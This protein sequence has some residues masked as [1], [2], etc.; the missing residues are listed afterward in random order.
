VKRGKRSSSINYFSRLDK[1]PKAP[2]RLFAANKNK[3]PKNTLSD[4]PGS[5]NVCTIVDNVSL[6]IEAVG[7]I[8]ELSLNAT[9]DCP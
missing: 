4:L 5:L 7:A 3:H 8:A 1:N 2:L 9:T 6:N